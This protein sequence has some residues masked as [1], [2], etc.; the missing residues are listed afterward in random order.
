MFG[1]NLDLGCMHQLVRS[2][3]RHRPGG[4]CSRNTFV[5]EKSEDGL[6]KRP[7]VIARVL[8]HINGDFLCC[9]PGEHYPFSLPRPCGD[10]TISL[11]TTACE[12]CSKPNCDVPEAHTAKDVEQPHPWTAVSNG[13]VRF[14][15]EKVVYPPRKPTTSSSR[16]LVWG[17]KRSVS[18]VM[19]R[20]IRKER[21]MFITSVPSGKRPP[22]RLMIAVPAA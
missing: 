11:R 10:A 4:G 9:T 15:L 7:Q 13:R 21:V 17:F 14:I 20:P 22:N 19:S 3:T 8:I 5:Q 6:V 1:Q 16:Q 2:K 18:K 12:H